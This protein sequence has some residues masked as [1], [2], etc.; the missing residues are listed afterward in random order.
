[1][2]PTNETNE[3]RETNERERLRTEVRRAAA[4]YAEVLPRA[5]KL[6]GGVRTHAWAISQHSQTLAENVN[7]RSD[8]M[9]EYVGRPERRLGAVRA[10]AARAIATRKREIASLNLHLWWRRNRRRVF[11][12]VA[13]AVAL[14]VTWFYW[15][16]ILAAL[17]WMWSRLE[18]TLRRLMTGYL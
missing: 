13:I 8:R 10:Q 11:W 3:R 4:L 7:Q 9:S 17:S 12:T 18:E 6:H 15:D 1:M 5:R 16:T 2:T 14:S